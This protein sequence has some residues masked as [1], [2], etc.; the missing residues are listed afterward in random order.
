MITSVIIHKRHNNVTVLYKRINLKKN[1]FYLFTH[2]PS[3]V[4]FTA[5]LADVTAA[6]PVYI[7]EHAAVDSNL[8]FP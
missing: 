8:H 2:V 5:E 3:R 4:H 6:L 7:C 1:H